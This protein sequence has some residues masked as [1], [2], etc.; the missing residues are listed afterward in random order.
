MIAVAIVLAGLFGAVLAAVGYAW[1]GL[2]AMTAIGV[3]VIASMMLSS[4]PIARSL[5]LKLGTSGAAPLR[6]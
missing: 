1:F 3:Y 4:L 2:S 5:L 6:G